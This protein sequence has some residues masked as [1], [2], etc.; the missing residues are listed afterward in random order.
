VI[1]F[2]RLLSL[3]PVD[4]CIRDEVVQLSVG[5][6]RDWLLSLAMAEGKER[7]TILDP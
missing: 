3:I 6:D 2:V 1:C 4:L 7:V 5:S